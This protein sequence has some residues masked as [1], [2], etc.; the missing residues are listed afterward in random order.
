[1]FLVRIKRNR[2]GWGSGLVKMGKKVLVFGTFDILHPGHDF[3]LRE[4]RNCG[5]ILEVVIARDLTVKKVKGECPLNDESKRL[6]VVRNL[7][8]VNNA[9]LG[10]ED[11]KYRIIEELRPDVICLGYD[12]DSFTKD[13][14]KILN[15]RGLNPEIVRIGS[16]RPHMYKSSKLRSRIS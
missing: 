3:F 8:Y 12:Q 14:R 16:F 4:A 1:M 10:H 6:A 11:D 9:Y 5:D 15:E 2:K 13:L 7:E